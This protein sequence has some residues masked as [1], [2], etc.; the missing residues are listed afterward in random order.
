MDEKNKNAQDFNLTT[1]NIRVPNN[2]DRRPA[3]GGEH[4]RTM[5]NAPYPKDYGSAPQSSPR[6]AFDLTA[7]NFEAPGVEDD[8][9]VVP[10]PRPSSS[11]PQFQP[12]EQFQPPPQQQATFRQP[13][14]AMAAPA[15]KRRVPLWAWLGGGALMLLLLTV[16]GVM[17]LFVL[18]RI[19]PQP[20]TLKVL[21]APAGSKVLIDG[22]NI[23]GVQHYGTIIIQGLR[24]GEP[25]DVRVIHEGYQD[26]NTTVT[27]E[28]GETL[29]VIVKPLPNKANDPP[30]SEI[31]YTGKMM[32]VP[33][34]A[35]TMG[36]DNHHPDERPAHQVEV[37][38]FYIDKYEVTNELYKKF[39]DATSR[40][41]P[42]SPWWDQQYFDS[43]PQAP[44]VG[45]SWDDAAKYAEWA[46]KR[47]PK[48]EEWEKAASWDPKTKTKR[49]WPW[50]DMPEQGRANVGQKIEN[51]KLLTVG[52]NP[53]G[54]SAYGVH[55]MIGNAGEW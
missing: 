28:S 32:L 42:P 1:P 31:D 10:P 15:P 25:R 12:Q 16:G 53:G 24:A 45:I 48:E 20:F 52:Q 11:P 41:Y 21:N 27:G 2:P 51:L 40:P 44:V 35:F 23:S 34:G 3:S 5:P 47:L 6:N 54:A 4:D 37:P 38:A 36:D 55:D 26:F 14:P 49:Q 30:L 29:E 46:G 33:A 19:W 8:D 9:E 50:G 39:C 17:L 43:K 18:P 13:S 7:V 22:K